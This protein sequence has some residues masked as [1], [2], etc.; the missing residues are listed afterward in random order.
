MKIGGKANVE[1]KNV[2]YDKAIIPYVG[3]FIRAVGR[4]R[5]SNKQSYEK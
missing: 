1:I 5:R 3:C 2:R 4:I